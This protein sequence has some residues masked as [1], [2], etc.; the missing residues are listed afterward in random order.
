MSTVHL[1]RL[2]SIFFFSDRWLFQSLDERPQIREERDGLTP[3]KEGPPGGSLASPKMEIG[4]S[5]KNCSKMAEARGRVA[6][7]HILSSKKQM[8][9]EARALVRS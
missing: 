3:L 4:T 2:L 5:T 7:G 9:G 6:K 1:P 8:G